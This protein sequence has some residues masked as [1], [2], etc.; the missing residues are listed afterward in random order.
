MQK[1]N[2]FLEQS[3]NANVIETTA[4]A[5][6]EKFEEI[7]DKAKQQVDLQKKL[8]PSGVPITVTLSEKDIDLL[9]GMCTGVVNQ[10]KEELKRC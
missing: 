1:S 4:R 6:V 10:I 7:R 2:N 3:K 8:K 9:L 5:F